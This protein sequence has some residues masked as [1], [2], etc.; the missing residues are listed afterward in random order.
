MRKFVS[1]VFLLAL[2]LFAGVSCRNVPKDNIAQGGGQSFDEQMIASGNAMISAFKAGNY[3]AFSRFLSDGLKRDFSGDSFDSGRRQVVESAGEVR[4]VRY[5]GKL[6]GPVF[7]NFLWAVAFSRNSGNKPVEQ[8][9]LF[10]LTAAQD[11]QG[12]RVISFGFML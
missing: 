2:C 10:K 8:E 3:Q 6:A 7:S 9:L 12:A 11:E 4:G 5:I 1:L